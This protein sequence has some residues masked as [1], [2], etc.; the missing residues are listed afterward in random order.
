MNLTK[1]KDDVYLINKILKT[2]TI[3]GRKK[4][5]VNWLG[6]DEKLQE[7]IDEDDVKYIKDMDKL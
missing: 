5:L 6:Y 1:Q 2:K 4:Y 7:W 3:K